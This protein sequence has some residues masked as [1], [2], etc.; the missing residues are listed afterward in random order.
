MEIFGPYQTYYLCY[1]VFRIKI[2]WMTLVWRRGHSFLRLLVLINPA[3]AIYKAKELVKEKI[4]GISNF[5]FF[6][7]TPRI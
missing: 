3:T 2:G 4:G 1:S 6:T 7:V 5:V